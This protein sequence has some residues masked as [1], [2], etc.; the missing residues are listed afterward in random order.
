MSNLRLSLLHLMA[1]EPPEPDYELTSIP[2]TR[3]SGFATKFPAHGREKHA[4]I[5]KRRKASKMAARNRKRSRK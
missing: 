3:G 4:A 1:M 5:I 2:V